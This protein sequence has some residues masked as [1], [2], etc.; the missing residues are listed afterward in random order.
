MNEKYLNNTPSAEKQFEGS[1][2][3][4]EM[5]ILLTRVEAEILSSNIP[6]V[7]KEA[8]IQALESISPEALFQEADS[9]LRMQSNQMNTRIAAMT[10]VSRKL[11]NLGLSEAEYGDTTT[12]SHLIEVIDTELSKRYR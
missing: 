11:R 6:P 7:Q 1:E 3:L 5:Q 8:V 2:N 4:N 9:L 10:L 12:L